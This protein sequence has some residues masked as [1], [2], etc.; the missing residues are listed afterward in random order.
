MIVIVTTV[1]IGVV[2]PIIVSSLI[3]I[4]ATIIEATIADRKSVAYGQNCT[5]DTNHV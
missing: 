1:I 4:I 5:T 3:C 2:M